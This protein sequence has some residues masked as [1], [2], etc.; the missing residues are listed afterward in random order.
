MEPVKK[1][2]IRNDIAELQIQIEIEAVIREMVAKF[3]HYKQVNKRFSDAFEGIEGYRAWLYKDHKHALHVTKKTGEWKSVKVELYIYGEELTWE[4][5]L[6]E[7]DRCN[8]KKQLERAQYKLDNFDRELQEL[9]ELQEILKD[10]ELTNFSLWRIK[11]DIA[12]TIDY[13]GE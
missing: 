1:S 13:S 7:L 9:K 5:I 12:H 4:K 6:R 2:Q 11:S 8:F 3:Q 10:K